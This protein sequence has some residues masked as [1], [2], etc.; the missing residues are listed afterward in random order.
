MIRFIL[1]I[2]AVVS[3]ALEL[4]GDEIAPKQAPKLSANTADEPLAK[5][6]SLGKAAEFLDAAS[7]AW[8]KERGCFTCHTNYSYLYARPLVS[9]KAPAHAE[10]RKALENLVGVRWKD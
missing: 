9:G 8:N 3:L 10:V 4:R 5:S 6:F 2:C 7:L 1:A